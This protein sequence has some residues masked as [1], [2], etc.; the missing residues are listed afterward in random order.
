MA[1][2][3]AVSRTPK[4]IDPKLRRTRGPS[5]EVMNRDPNRHYVLANMNDP[6]CGQG[7]YEG[8]GYIVETLR[9][10]GPKL[11]GMRTCQPGEPIT[12]QGNVLMSVELE[13][14]EDIERFGI[15]GDGGME[16]AEMIENKIIDKNSVVDLLRG[17]HGR[18]NGSLRVIN[19]TSEPLPDTGD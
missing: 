14:R 19:Q 7:F 12:A 18:R 4:R 10:D 8:I 17:L 9:P 1:A 2:A 15:N 5:L 16:A 3:A 11:R 13:V 6:I